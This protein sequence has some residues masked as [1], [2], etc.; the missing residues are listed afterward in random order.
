VDVN[1]RKLMMKILRPVALFLV[2]T[3]LDNEPS[4]NGA[5]PY[6]RYD[7]V[8]GGEE[9]VLAQLKRLMNEAL[10]QFPEALKGVQKPV[11]ELIDLS[12]V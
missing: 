1:V 3:P 6:N 9:T 5:A 8:Q 4:I 12:T 10:A 7:F 11:G 2:S